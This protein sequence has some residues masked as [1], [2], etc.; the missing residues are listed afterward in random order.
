MAAACYG[1]TDVITTLLDSGANVNAINMVS[2]SVLGLRCSV[3]VGIWYFCGIKFKIELFSL[4]LPLH[5]YLCV[6]VCVCV[7][8]NLCVCVC[9]CL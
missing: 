4:P 2:F 5:V 6:C 3:Y 8:V 9:V 7:C 1:N